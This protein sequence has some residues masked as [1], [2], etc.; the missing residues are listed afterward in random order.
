MLNYDPLE[1]IKCNFSKLNINRCLS[2]IYLLYL[3]S[4]VETIDSF[5][6][7][8]AK[9]RL[10]VPVAKLSFLNSPITYLKEVRAE[11]GKVVWP[12]RE[13]TI[14]YSVLVIVIAILTGAFLGGLDFLLTLLS[15]Y[16]VTKFGG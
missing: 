11:L 14:R 15:H 7:P 4:G 9:P 2:E 13:Q 12:T 3:T 16:L 10:T 1:R 6:V 5:F 8:M